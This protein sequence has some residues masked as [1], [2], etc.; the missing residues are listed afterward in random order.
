VVIH[1]LITFRP[2]AEH[3]DHH[4]EMYFSTKVKQVS[5]IDVE[6]RLVGDCVGGGLRV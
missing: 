6:G 2:L 1:P 5:E 3:S 4:L